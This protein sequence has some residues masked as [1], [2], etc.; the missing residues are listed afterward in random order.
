MCAFK[1]E[2]FSRVFASPNSLLKGCVDAH[3]RSR[4]LCKR[5]RQVFLT[6]KLGSIWQI[7]SRVLH[8]F[9]SL[10][11]YYERVMAGGARPQ[12]DAALPDATNVR[13]R[14]RS[15]PPPLSS[16]TPP[17][18]SAR[19]IASGAAS[20]QSPFSLD[21]GDKA[22]PRQQWRSAKRSAKYVAAFVALRALAALIVWLIRKM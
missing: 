10:Q 12:L 6:T 8:F 22:A 3:V 2:T 15:S 4:I 16:S 14:A 7:L 19:P 20:A 5:T 21:R 11:R 1:F 18:R 17:S 13:V 9:Y